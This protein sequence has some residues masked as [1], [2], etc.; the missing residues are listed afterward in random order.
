MAQRRGKL[1]PSDPRVNRTLWQWLA[2]GVLSLLLFPAARGFDLWLGWLPF[3]AVIAPL[4][5][6]L[7]LHRHVLMTAWRGV[8]VPAPRRRRQRGS[9]AQARRAGFGSTPHRQSRHAA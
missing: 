2:L 3:W 1:R 8:L 5:A 4:S 7:V 9:D 6:L